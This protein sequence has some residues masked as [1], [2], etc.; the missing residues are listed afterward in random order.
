MGKFLDIIKLSSLGLAVFLVLPHL[1]QAHNGAVALAVPVEG[2]VVDGDLSDWPDD[3]VRHPITRSEY[4]VPPVD[5]A[6]LSA[7]FR[8][9]YDPT[10]TLY[11]AIEVTDESI[12]IDTS[13]EV[14]WNSGDGC[15]V[16]LAVSHREG[17][18]A[19]AQYAVY[20]E[21]LIVGNP[22]RFDYRAVHGDG[23]HHYEWSVRLP[24][25]TIDA[26]VKI[27]LTLGVDL[28]IEDKDQDGSFSWLSWGKGL[29][30]YENPN[31][32]GDVL[33]VDKGALGFL[34]G[35]L[36]WKTQR[37][38]A[39]GELVHIESQANPALRVS[40][41]TDRSG[42][43][44]L[45]LPTG[46]Y[47]L[48]QRFSTEQDSDR[49]VDVLAGSEVDVSLELSQPPP[50]TKVAGPGDNL[51]NSKGTRYGIW[52]YIDAM[53]GVIYHI[54]ALHQSRTGDMW[55]GTL[56]GIIRYD[57]RNLHFWGI[58][59]G[60]PDDQIRALVEDHTG[61][62]WIGTRGGLVRYDGE[63]FQIYTE[64]HG[65]PNDEILAL[66]EDRTGHIW[67]GTDDGLVRYDGER[68][69]KFTSENGLPNDAVNVLLESRD[70]TLWAGTESGIGRYDGESFMPLSLPLVDGEFTPNVIALAEDSEGDLWF[71][72][73][74]GLV[75]YDGVSLELFTAEDGVPE[76]IPGRSIF[77]VLAFDSY[78]V[79]W[80]GNGARLV[81]FDGNLF[82]PVLLHDR[83][84]VKGN[85]LVVDREDN[86]WFS[87]HRG[88]AYL[89]NGTLV[90][91]GE[92]EGLAGEIWQFLEDRTGTYWVGTSEGLYRYDG[93]RYVEGI[94]SGA[95]SGRRIDF[96]Y[97]DRQNNLWINWYDGSISGL[98]NYDGSR[99]H[100]IPILASAELGPTRCMEE[101][102]DGSLWIGTQNGGLY[103]Y[104][105]DQ[106][107][108]FTVENGLPSNR[109]TDL[110]EMADGSLL[111]ATEG[112][113]GRYR[114][115]QLT[116]ETD[117]GDVIVGAIALA[118]DGN[119]WV[120]S[121][122]G[123]YRWDGERF[124]LVDL[125]KEFSRDRIISMIF[126]R[127]GQLWIGTAVGIY[128]YDGQVVQSIQLRDGLTSNSVHGVQQSQDGSFWLL[129][130]HSL[131]RY[132]VRR[133]PPIVKSVEVV[134]DRLYKDVD[135][136][137]L[138]L[139]QPYLAFDLHG[140][141]YKTLAGNL[142]YRYRLAG[143]QDIWQTT[144]ENRIEYRDL[145]MGTYHFEVE[146]VDRDLHYSPRR[147]I[148]IDIHFPYRQAALYS[149]LIFMFSGI[150]LSVVRIIR[151]NRG[152]KEAR[153]HAE[154]A[155]Q[156][157]S[158]FLANM[159]HEIRTPM[160]GIIGM[161][162]LLLNSGPDRVQRNYLQTIDTSAESLLDIIN[163]LLDL[164]KIEADKVALERIDFS[165][166][167]VLDGVAKLM[168]IRA[169]AKNLEL[170][171]HLVPGTPEGLVGDPV[172]L[173]QIFINLVGNAIK[174]TE[175]GEVVIEVSCAQQSEASVV[176][177]VS[178][179]DTGPGIPADAQARIFEAFSQ[180]DSSTT[181]HFG[182]TGLGLTI[183]SRLV[184]MMG[185]KLIVQSA[186]GKG[187]TFSFTLRLALSEKPV[188][189]R[190]DLL[191]ERLHNLRLLGVDD[192]ATNRLVLEEMLRS[193]DID[194]SIVD[195]GPAALEM[196]QRAEREGK[197][198]DLVLLDAMMPAIDGLDLAREIRAQ[199]SF[200]GV[201]MLLLSSTDDQDYLNRMKELNVTAHVRKPITRSDLLNGIADALA[202]SSPEIVPTEG[203]QG[204][205][206]QEPRTGRSM[207]VLLAEDDKVNQTVATAMIGRMGHT[208]TIANNGREVLELLDEREFDLILMDMQMPEMGGIE[209]TETIRRRERE[210]GK[211]IP[212]V[213]LTAN[214]MKSDENR[215]LAAGMD[216]YVS[217]P[218]RQ[219][220]LVETIASLDL[221]E[222]DETDQTRGQDATER[223]LDREALEDLKSLEESGEFSLREV[224]EIFVTQ[225]DPHMA[226]LRQALA[227][228]NG[229]DLERK[230][231]TLRSSAGDLGAIR[232]AEICQ[233]VEESG[234]TSS[235]DGVEEMLVGVEEEFT[236]ARGEL[237]EYLQQTVNR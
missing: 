180:A 150:V 15:D 68:F 147:S 138:P 28:S 197:P 59:D 234:R 125:G 115:G 112:G 13:D 185:G 78:G 221:A 175:T 81:R 66:L 84:S 57:S 101:T 121:N 186:E 230:A 43:F 89:E 196:M 231:N 9:G 31:R 228:R 213:G 145:P 135:R 24:D 214:A 190:P 216:A 119:A 160:N 100:T 25:E 118:A 176:L 219:Q 171:C 53:E 161:T 215:C 179:R 18:T 58:E 55:I 12:V 144:T 128:R 73:V 166:R 97:A 210:T 62:L 94:P 131:T 188:E 63:T 102:R 2:I 23:F 217:K 7:S 222:N 167:E 116:R 38:P 229:T 203:A 77:G 159:S 99:L 42:S 90:N 45:H 110:Q 130:G 36:H 56:G 8:I 40:V 30:K 155:N 51:G 204:T 67:I 235:F 146:A 91:Q 187:S 178:I 225:G 32:L 149:L 88:L 205:V 113:L 79:L 224:I 74:E 83:S 206:I 218:V 237:L 232:L 141:S 193:W 106:L 148:E 35:N 17:P 126:D 172:R 163:D 199:P 37:D 209:T 86:L 154:Q 151:S 69:E 22:E 162:E 168:A 194:S 137:K 104:F 92:A 227:E 117:L 61:A 34:Q 207:R 10:G 182:G 93:Q 71:R 198:Y 87:S 95:L 183:S 200:D 212:I 173:R 132:R 109:V 201:I 233:R 195:N 54:T 16:Y 19:I 50:I 111:I 226:G 220:L 105:D 47:T 41:K 70:G 169:H 107:A 152:L 11:I 181:R 114:D 157:K 108:R 170:V 123:I 236:R 192:N 129:N 143:H 133:A 164:S 6:D 27:P 120:A 76:L 3:L 96:L 124:A 75:H 191:M 52:S 72:V 80:E 184:S 174:F 202:I 140:R 4:G 156:A 98:A 5:S 44:D 49:A 46:R 65:L 158:E 142:I 60:L 20:S 39:K 29:R 208:A 136:L 134:A 64:E 127:E 33:L 189:R 1:A 211:H 82:E 48:Q 85:A 139:G 26:G 223:I 21:D 14:R 103:R 153:L 177:N 165:L 122:S